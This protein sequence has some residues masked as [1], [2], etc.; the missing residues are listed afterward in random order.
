MDVQQAQIPAL[1]ITDLPETISSDLP[2]EVQALIDS[3]DFLS[4]EAL[5]EIIE[6]VVEILKKE[7]EITCAKILKVIACVAASSFS[8]IQIYY[9]GG[10]FSKDFFRKI[11]PSLTDEQ[12]EIIRQIFALISAGVNGFINTRTSVLVIDS[13]V[14]SV[15]QFRATET[16]AEKAKEFTKFTARLIFGLVSAVST[17]QLVEDAVGNKWSRR[18]VVDGLKGVLF[19]ITMGFTFRGIDGCI[20][21]IRDSSLL[22]FIPSIKEEQERAY[23]IRKRV[24]MKL[25]IS[26]GLNL[27]EECI[28]SLAKGEIYEGAPPAVAKIFL[29]LAFFIIPAVFYAYASYFVAAKEATAKLTGS[30]PNSLWDV[31]VD[32]V[33]AVSAVVGRA[34]LVAN[35][36]NRI[37]EGFWNSFGTDRFNPP[38]KQVPVSSQ[39]KSLLKLAVQE[40]LLIGITSCSLTGAMGAVEEY[41]F[42]NLKTLLNLSLS[43]GISLAGAAN[44]NYE[45]LK[46]AGGIIGD[47]GRKFW[48]RCCGSPDDNVKEPTGREVARRL[49][50]MRSA[51][52]VKLSETKRLLFFTSINT[53]QGNAVLD[54]SIPFLAADSSTSFSSPRHSNSLT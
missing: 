41:Y 23:G 27:A 44:I 38:K 49:A 18:W 45:D 22:R 48:S 29:K 47:L 37:G 14:D 31:V 34:L 2:E 6:K 13:V 50:T 12:L 17:L 46:T 36:A 35:S 24:F 11:D 9:F 10:Q 5:V 42:G 21:N 3:S 39:L 52:V 20:A 26:D 19:F 15:Q 32:N 1:T 54:Q 4:Q 43:I 53:G 40:A 33:I 7:D 51:E 25:N 30:D 16:R 8:V 28:D